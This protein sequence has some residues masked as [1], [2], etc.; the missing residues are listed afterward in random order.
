MLLVAAGAILSKS[1]TPSVRRARAAANG[2]SKSARKS[3]TDRPDP[4]TGARGP[5][6]FLPIVAVGGAATGFP[7]DPIGS[8]AR[9]A[10]I[11]RRPGVNGACR[12]PGAVSLQPVR[13]LLPISSVRRRGGSR[14]K[15]NRREASECR[16]PLPD[17]PFA[18][19]GVAGQTVLSPPGEGRSHWGSAHRGTQLMKTSRQQRLPIE[20]YALLTENA[21]EL[22]AKLDHWYSFYQPATP[23]ECEQL[24]MAVMASVQSAAGAR[25]PDRDGEPGDSHRGLRLRLRPGRRGRSVPGDARDPARTRRWSG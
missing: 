19:G 10:P 1:A 6:R 12:G 16:P 11:L 25:V 15:R 3:T 17:P 21:P 9:V 23:G 4:G 2:L 20:E 8:T 18:R 14:R 13:S 22:G 5:D 7:D 24:D